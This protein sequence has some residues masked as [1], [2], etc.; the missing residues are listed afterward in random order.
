MACFITPLLAG[1][2]V[3][4][5]NKV[6]KSSSGLKLN[7]LFYMLLGGALVLA[8]EHAWHGELVPHPPF[9]TAMQNPEDL[10]M[11]LNEISLVGGSMTLAVATLWLGIV[12]ISKKL[13]ARSA[14]HTRIF[15]T[16]GIK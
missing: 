12:G 10:P 14:P 2:I 16:L 1:L 5:L 13:K 7:A 6:R 11:L 9:L 15:T 8:T 4:L 3:G